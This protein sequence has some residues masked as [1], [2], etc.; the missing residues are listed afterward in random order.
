M[1]CIYSHDSGAYCDKHDYGAVTVGCCG[2][3]SCPDRKIL[4]N[5]DRIR[6]MTVEDLAMLLQ[7][8]CPIRVCRDY[9]PHDCYT[10]WLEWLKSPVEDL[11]K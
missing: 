2:D 3:E 10:C 8:G 9:P 11:E 1:N 6:N 4:T 7:P 5:A